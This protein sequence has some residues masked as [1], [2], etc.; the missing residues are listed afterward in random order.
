MSQPSNLVLFLGRFHVLLVHLPIGLLLLLLA[1][2]AVA[3]FTR[4][5]HA[6]AGSG[7]ILALAVP[8]AVASATCGWLLSQA[9]GYDARLL[10][11]HKWL[12]FAT[13]GA[14]ALAA[15]LYWLDRQ[16]LYQACLVLACAAL[17]AA[18]HFGGSLTHGSDYLTR[19]APGPLRTWLAGKPSARPAGKP[20]A[21][22]NQTAFALVVQPVLQ[23]DCASC[24]GPDKAKK[25]LRL[26]SF[27]ALLK[28]GKDGPGI[29]P[30]DSSA[31]AIIKR[32]LAP[33][34]DDDHMPPEG[35]PQPTADDI[36]L[37]RWWIDAG[38]PADKK[39]TELKAPP[40]VQRL[41][42]RRSGAFAAGGP[43][44]PPKPLNDVLPVAERLSADLGISISALAENAPWLQA[45]A[46]LAGTNFGDADLAKLAP[47][48]ANLRWLDLARTGVGDTG[49]VQVAQMRNLQRLHLERTAVTDAGL[50]QL[51]GL[52]ELAYLNLYGTH[53]TDAGL[54]CLK[55][56]TRLRQLYL[57]ETKVAPQAA[58]ALADQLED[59]DQIV[60]WQ[61]EI[62]A[63]QTRIREA[64]VAVDLGVPVAAAKPAAAKPVNAKCP[65][66]GK[67]ID[68]TKTVVFEG[69]VIAFCCDDCKAKFEKDPKPFLAKLE[70][71]RPP[72]AAPQPN[73]QQSNAKCPVS[74]KDIDPAKTVLHDGKLVAFCCD[75]CKAKFQQDPKPFLV[76]LGLTPAKAVA[77]ANQ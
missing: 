74:G 24:H 72:A 61:Q 42:E 49:L 58:K 41:L 57:W 19:Y 17:V 20:G 36:A 1:Q 68:P 7:F 39:L 52:R 29:Q 9:G 21:G 10:P 16:R 15:V 33:L 56:L 40:N 8:A 53:I 5:K 28:G 46:S 47:L 44:L 70:L 22:T 11:L 65:V 67:D 23:A 64:S 32:M 14:C 48:Q 34:D 54:E 50:A 59:K 13:V 51:A 76:K 2:E 27:A 31:S 37:I 26:D 75:D 30:G 69:K 45:N 12:G 55:P 18:S 38:A 73:A 62:A 77:A 4:F 63:L 60:R 3:R 66:S 25:G 71:A 43:P 6:G 35:K